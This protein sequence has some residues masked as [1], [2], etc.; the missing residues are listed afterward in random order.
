MTQRVN[1]AEDLMLAF[2]DAGPDRADRL[3]DIMIK[4][5]RRGDGERPLFDVLTLC[6]AF[7][8]TVAHAR[9]QAPEVVL[10]EYAAATRGAQ[11]QWETG[12]HAV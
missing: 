11:E 9:H 5:D 2:L 8:V 3:A 10:A 6:A 1:V 4:A 12:V 7:V